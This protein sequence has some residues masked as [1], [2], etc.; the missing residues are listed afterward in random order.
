MRYENLSRH[1]SLF[2]EYTEL[3]VQENTAAS[4]TSV[5]GDIVNNVQTK[6]SGVSAR[7]F[8]DGVW[9]FASSPVRT[10]QSI[11]SSVKRAT[12]NVKFLAKKAG[13]N[14]KELP[15]FTGRGQ[16]GKHEP[17]K[18]ASQKEII[19]FIK[20]LENYTKKKY[21]ELQ[22]R[23]F[24]LSTNGT[25]RSLVTSDKAD[26]YS[27]VPR[28]NLII[29]LKLIANGEP[30][31]LYDVFGGLGQF[32]DLFNKPSEY[33]AK[34]DTVVEDLKKKAEG[35]YAK[36][37][38][39]DVV[40]GPDLAGILAHEA[41][42]H[43]TEA[44]FV[45][46]GSIAADFMNKPVATPLVTLVDFA[47]EYNGKLCPVPIWIDD[48]GVAAKD[49]VIIKDGILNSY[50]HNKQSAAIF[51]VNPTGNARANEFSD[52]PLVRMRNT[53]ILPGKDKLAD[54]ISS[55]ENGYYFI[56]SSNGQADSTSEFMFGVVLGYEIKNGK[57]GKALRDCTIAGVA[58]DMLKTVTM[59]SD[60]MSWSN[61]GWCGKKQLINV[62]MGGPAIKC[63]IGV[64]GR[65]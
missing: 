52:E 53:A 34:I 62:G 57:L 14:Q 20:D 43:T 18:D 10:E 21:P 19:D 24:R 64:G 26:A 59:I 17:S 1:A 15:A 6:T 27:F 31:D 22:S 35:V 41:I 42:G 33:Y 37:G 9:G 11:A 50:M 63:K 28:A 45:M 7:A 47:Y 8:K 12:E 38:I 39:H 49:A 60:D 23:T 5:N 54:M 3:R 51:K 16:H 25:E 56:R 55:I 40:L 36:P 65:E 58:F 32:K 29:Q 48:E 30:V 44:D 61:S 2:S 13:T 4:A 46:S